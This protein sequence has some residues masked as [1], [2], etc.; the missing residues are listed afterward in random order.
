[1]ANTKISAL[2]A[3]TNPSWLEEFVY[4]YNNAN[5]KIT[6]NTMKTFVWGA[7]IT[8]LNTDANIWELSGGIYETT[9][10]LYYKS[11]N[12][13]PHASWGVMDLKQM[14]F[15]IDSWIWQKAYFTF[16][17]ATI[18]T[19]T[20]SRASYW[21]SNSS[22]DWICN[23]LW[24]RDWALQ[25]YQ[26][27]VTTWWIDALQRYPITQVIDNISDW[28][29]EL[30][31]STRDW[32]PYPWLTYTIYINSVASWKTYTIT[33]WNWITNPFNIALPTASTKKSVITVFITSTTTGIVTWCTIES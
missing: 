15:I 26:P 25:E 12:A 1:M 16:N 3:N 32:E 6:L 4:A 19:S 27:L 8:T 10:E 11:W 7:G 24:S 31:I 17:E 30:R 5:G 20:Y 33:L 22:S 18:W 2:T 9:H 23:Q 21:Y 29:N 28:T 13:V 14:I